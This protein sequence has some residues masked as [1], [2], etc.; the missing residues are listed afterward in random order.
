MQPHRF[1]VVGLVAFVAACQSVPKLG[2]HAL[3][4][5][6]RDIQTLEVGSSLELSVSGLEPHQLFEVRLGIDG[7]IPDRD[8][9]ISF[10]R[11]S[12]DQRGNIEP[13][14]LWYHT[15]VV[16]CSKRRDP[17]QPL[18]PY[19][20]RSFEEAQR[21]LAGRQLTLSVHP[22]GRGPKNETAPLKLPVGD[23]ISRLDLPIVARKSP[24][25]YPSDAAGCLV[26]SAEARKQDF[27]VTG[28]NFLSGETLEI[29]IVENQRQWYV[30]D[31]VRDLTGERGTDAALSV[32]AD[33][34]GGFTVRAWESARQR[35]GVYDIIAQRFDLNDRDGDR[36][37][38]EDIVSYGR[39][40][41]YILYLYYPIGG[42]TMDIAGRPV[43]SPNPPY[44]QFAD[45]FAV[46]GDT[47]YGAVDPTY[48]PVDHPGGSYAA[49]YV[50]PHR[51]APGWN[52]DM[53]GA[54][55]LVDDDASGGI[56]IHPVKADCINA[57]DTPIWH[58]PLTLGEYDV[59]V[60]FGLNAA[61]SSGDYES[62]NRYD[63]EVDFLDGADQIGF[64]VAKDPW[65]RGPYDVGQAEYDQD[66]FF[67]TMR[68]ATN[69]D[70]RAV[71]RYPATSAGVNTPVVLGQHP[72][73]VIQHGNHRICEVATDG[74]PI[75]DVIA[76]HQ[77]GIITNAEL[78]SLKHNH[79]SCPVEDR[80]PN[81]HG[82]M[83]LL[84]VLASHGV[85]AVSIDAFD[86]T[87]EFVPQWIDERGTLILKH[88][89]LWSH[90]HDPTTFINYPDFFAGR[91]VNHIDLNK[92]SVSGHSR[93]GE[94]SVAAF[95]LNAE[96]ETPFSIGS[97]SSIAPTDGFMS[98]PLV[99]TEVPYF[100]ILPAADGDL[101]TLPG[102]RIY[103]RAGSTLT[104]VDSTTKSGIHVY[105]ANH[106]FFNTVW[107]DHNDDSWYPRD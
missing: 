33:A 19:S 83:N 27:F 21:H 81:H 98:L 59:V 74:R 102:T 22:V 82:Y 107:A 2:I 28:R 97:V 25:V 70:L 46:D 36:V 73:F 89:E 26:N 96:S 54:T 1:L 48:V 66:D 77:D 94:A 45:S 71:V 37:R 42:P 86:L 52:P 50:V 62:D 100:V 40:T 30:G 55:D 101:G 78:A 99:L 95:V 43:S 38:E 69:V 57:T 60:D 14:L 49:Y 13:F 64:I 6:G 75:D 8:A 3:D 61:E 12:T 15:G 105:G 35:R 76:E 7:E 53:G 92:I 58:G 91:F 56:E 88:L 80:T 16:G 20:F 63:E 23:P 9:A 18:A 85:I 65:D 39:D 5:G 67:A 11:V 104:P 24:M 72:L 87:A 34:Q 51:D 41:A 29:S 84:D 90:M 106:N 79:E 103:D 10:A 93:G 4:A 17:S 68:N 47:V 31:R 32:Q 44:F